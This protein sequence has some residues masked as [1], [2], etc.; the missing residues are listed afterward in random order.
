M[1]VETAEATPAVARA[2]ERAAADLHRFAR[3]HKAAAAAH[4]RSA[5][6]A[7]E[8]LA[9]LRADCAAAGIQLVI[10]PEAQTHDHRR[11]GQ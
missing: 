11:A 2:L 8:S 3:N 4:R 10:A 9:R 1:T 6:Q 7:M 5:Q